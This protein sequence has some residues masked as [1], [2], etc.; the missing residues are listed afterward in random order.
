V[1]DDLYRPGRD[2]DEEAR[3]YGEDEAFEAAPQGEGEEFAERVNE[4]IGGEHGDPAANLAVAELLAKLA[5]RTNE[6]QSAQAE[7]GERTADL[8]RLQAEYVNYR[9]RV[10]RDRTAVAE[11]ALGKVLTGLLPVLD[12]I[13]RARDHGELEGGFR[14]V[15][16]SL[17]NSLAKLGLEQFGAAGELFDPNVHEAL[18]HTVAPDVEEDTCVEIL[19]PG[20][21]LGDR[22]LR[23]ARVTVAQ[24]GEPGE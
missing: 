13:G 16:E 14:Q 19:Q 8:Q 20:Y 7:L 2:D 21:R 22:I 18:M 5:E 11:M 10:E 15:A 12:D 4:A 6:L 3:Q 1:S 17:E 9:R 23:V 24:P